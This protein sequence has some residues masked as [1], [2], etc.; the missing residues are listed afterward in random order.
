MKHVVAA[1]LALALLSST[2]LAG[3]IDRSGQGVNVLFEEG[4]FA[5][6][7]VT[8]VSPSVDGTAPSLAPVLGTSDDVAQ[9]YT[10]IGL[11]YKHEITDRLDAALIIDEP[12][13]AHILYTDGG[14]FAITP[15]GLPYDGTAEI[16]SQAI[17]ALLQYD[18]GSGFSVH[19]G[20]RALQVDGII[21]SGNGI[22]Q[23]DSDYDFGYVIGAA[24]EKPEIALRVALTYNSSIDVG[25]SGSQQQLVAPNPSPAFISTSPDFVVEF[26]ESVNLDFQT[27]IAQNTLLF[28][29][30]RWVGWDGFNLTTAGAAGDL[31]WVNFEDDTVSYEL[32]IGRKINEKLSVA[33]AVGYESAGTRPSTTA[34]APTTGSRSIGVAGTYQVNENLSI[35]GGIRYI[36]PGDQYV[37]SSAGN[38][39]FNDNSAVAVGIRVGY[40]F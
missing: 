10:D 11:G 29:S 35:S 8:H 33:L 36:E 26:P 28:G 1:P 13:G 14:P 31:E 17:T 25:L 16:N 40:H 5:Q 7:T 34:L 4:N 2:A 9:S 15:T 27:G 21:R 38:V 24:Y 32:G 12:F 20:I 6:F 37:T 30:V 22:L 23:A 19:G 3:G 18:L 39:E